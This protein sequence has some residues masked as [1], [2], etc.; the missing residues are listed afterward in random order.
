LFAKVVAQSTPQLIAKPLYAIMKKTIAI[1]FLLSLILGCQEKENVITVFNKDGIAIKKSFFDIND[2]L[3][4]TIKFYER[5]PEV[6]YKMVFKKDNYD[7]IVYKY[8]NGKVFKT[9]K[10]TLDSLLT[11]IWN[12]YDREGKLREIR[13]FFI[14]EGKSKLNRAW[15]LNKKGDTVAWNDDNN[16]FDQKEFVHDTLSIRHSSYNIFQFNKDTIYLN[17]PIRGVAYCFSPRIEDKYNSQIRVFLDTNDEKF[18]FDFSN[19]SIIR[20]QGYNNLEIDTI[21]QKWFD[22]ISK[23]DFRYTAVFGSW[24][25]N[26]GKK[27]LQGYME[28]YAIGPFQDIDADSIT[29]RIYFRKEIF[30]KDTLNK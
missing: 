8:D 25:E 26:P 9:G 4:K 16:V 27:L 1:L 18:T 13:E 2:K 23:E 3:V 21:N 22:D 15:F 12:L 17:E 7:S 29:S 19:D 11:G 24:F 28:E 14:V 30:V 10:K 6:E 5:N 20:K